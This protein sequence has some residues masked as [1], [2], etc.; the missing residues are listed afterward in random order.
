MVKKLTVLG[1]INIDHILTL[2]EFPHPGETQPGHDYQQTFG[3]KGANQAVAA[4]RAGI[5]TQFIAAVGNDE[6]GRIIVN[7]LKKE[8]ILTDT[9][10][11][12]TDSKTGI[13]LIF[14]N[15]QGENEIG[16]YGGANSRI[17]ASLL[18]QYRHQIIESDMLLLQLEIPIA[19]IELAVQWANEADI[20]V[21]LNCAPA[22]PLKKSLLAQISIIIAN[23]SEAE[24]LT[25]IRIVDNHRT[26]KQAASILHQ[27]GIATVI[28]TLGVRGIF[29]SSNDSSYNI[30][31]HSVKVADTIGAG[32]TFCGA[33]AAALLEGKSLAEAV[34]FGNCAAAISVTRKGTQLA[35][36]YKHQILD[37]GNQIPNN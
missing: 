8:C 21:I 6:M 26:P 19:A 1:S 2:T 16:I 36:P 23:Q 7:A 33:F 20:P 30:A 31:A 17:D 29:V 13:A 14:V 10:A 22:M 9:I 27:K 35:I 32:D 24:L 18:V 37:F 11:V 12:I 15:Q 28:I 3:G 5:T 34:Q 25:G 4:A